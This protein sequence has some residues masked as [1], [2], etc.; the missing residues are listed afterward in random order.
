MRHHFADKS[1]LRALS[2]PK[3]RV[4]L[5]GS[6]PLAEMQLHVRTNDIASSFDVQLILDETDSRASREREIYGIGKTALF[7]H[8]DES[9]AEGNINA[10]WLFA[11]YG[12]A[13]FDGCHCM[14]FV[15]KR[16]AGHID[17]IGLRI[18]DDVLRRFANPNFRVFCARLRTRRRNRV[19]ARIYV[20]SIMSRNVGR[21]A[22]A[23]HAKPNNRNLVVI[24]PYDRYHFLS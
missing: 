16:R 10:Q 19:P 5:Q 20:E 8:F 1:T 13:G 4:H 3:R 15:P 17:Q 6:G 9:A 18:V 12:L 11:K 7:G 22:S 2:Q 23:H 21:H 24:C 14:R